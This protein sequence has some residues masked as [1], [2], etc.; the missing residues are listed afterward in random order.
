MK[1]SILNE[2]TKPTILFLVLSLF[3]L[4][5][6]FGQNVDA[7]WT[8]Y[9]G[10]WNSS[11]NNI[12][13]I[14]P[15]NSHNLLA[16]RYDG[17]VYSTG[18]NDDALTTNNVSFT[19]GNWRA[20]PINSITVGSCPPSPSVAYL[21]M[22]AQLVDGV[23]NGGSTTPPFPVENNEC[24]T[25]EVMASFLTQGENGLDL[26]SGIANIPSGTVLS[27]PFSN[28]GITQSNINDGEPD[29][30]ITQLLAPGAS[31]D[32][33][34]IVDANGNIVGNPIDVNQNNTTIVGNYRA[35]LYFRNGNILDG[36]SSTFG[37]TANQQRPIRLLAFELSDFGIN[38][39]NYTQATKLE[40][41][42]S[43][44]SDPAFFAFNE[45]SIS[46]PTSLAVTNEPNIYTDA[47]AL[48][49][50]FTVVIQ[51]DQASTV[52]EAG[53]EITA[54]IES[55][56]GTLSGD[57]TATTDA[58]GVATFSNLVINGSGDQ[59]L[60]FTSSSLNPA[61]SNVLVD[62]IAGDLTIGTSASGDS[63]SITN[64]RLISE[65]TSTIA[66]N[67]IINHL[68]N[69]GD[70]II[71]A[72][73]GE[74]IIS[75]D[76]TPN[77]SSSRV[78]SFKAEG[79]IVV[80]DDIEISASGSAMDLVFWSDTDAN[81]EGGILFRDGSNIESNNGH[82]WI[83]GGNGN[84]T[85]N[86][87]T[88]GDSYAVGLSNTATGIIETYAGI[89]AVGNALLAGSGD[90][91]LSGK[92]TQTTYRFGI[93]VRFNTSGTKLNLTGNNITISG[94]GSENNGTSGDT[95]RGNWG[96]GIEKT[97]IL[98]SG[99]IL[100]EGTGGGQNLTS[101][102]TNGGGN[103]GVR[104]DN[105]S[106]IIST[107]SGD[108]SIIGS[109]GT[110]SG[111]SNQDND[112]LRLDGGTIRV[113]TGSLSLHGTA[114]TNGSSQGI[115]YTNG[116]M[117]SRMPSST[118]SNGDLK[119]TSNTLN[120]STGVRLRSEGEL[121]ITP[122]SETTNIGIAGATGA[123]SL[124]SSYFST[125]FEDGFSNIIIG[126]DNQ[127]GDITCNTI[128]FEDNTTLQTDGNL[129]F[130]GN[131]ST[132]ANT[133]LTLI[134]N[135]LTFNTA[136]T[137][138]VQGSFAYIPFGTSFTSHV[139]FPMANLSLGTSISGLTIGNAT[140]D[141]NITINADVTGDAGIEL[142]GNDID[143]NANLETTNSANI[144]FKGNTTI[145]AGKH[146]ASNGNFTHDGDLLFK[147]D[148]TNGDAYLGSIEGNYTKTSGT[149]IT[150]KFYP[151][152]RAFRMVASP[153]DGVSI[154]DNWQN[155]GA[156]ETGIGTHI[157]GSETGDNG[158]DETETGNPSLFYF[159]NGWQAIPN[160][161]AINLTAG[162]PYR[163]MV[164]GDRDPN[165]LIDN[166]ADPNPTTLVATG[167][168]IVGTINI[169]FPSATAGSNTFAFIANPYQS[170]I[171]VSEVLT[172]NNS[173][174]DDTKLWVWDPMIN[175]RGAFV[176]I[177]ELSSGNGDTTP[178]SDAT[179]F[180]EP[181][182]A[183]FIQLIGTDSTISFTE[184]VK[185]ITT[186]LNK[187]APLSNNQMSLLF[188]LQNEENK[189][190]DAIR[191][192]FAADGITEVDAADIA[193]MGNIDE[194]LASVNQNSLFS[195]QRR[196]F[197]ENDEVIPLFTNNW[198]NQNYSFV[199]NLSNLGDVQVYMVDAYLGTETLLADGEAYHFSVDANVAESVDSQRFSLKFDAE[200]MSMEDV[201]KKWFSLYPN[202]AVD[203]VQLQ[204]NLALTGK[205]NVAVYNMLGQQ[206]QVKA[207][208]ISHSNLRLSLGHL[209]SGVYI[210][211]LTDREG[212]SY[213]QE[214]IKK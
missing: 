5:N 205:A 140:N 175:T 143:I 36:G 139:T 93:G 213:T 103:H 26:G 58:N 73:G 129:T 172:A 38:S 152:K 174:A 121:V 161:N 23:D 204:S 181:G 14:E 53:T 122:T 137:F 104:M 192:R 25:E 64:G 180:I 114:G 202:P 176:T 12:N 195:I 131:V 19:S 110:P 158:F 113:N 3:G 193:K 178:S 108:I 200:T 188:E 141:K 144:E 22:L 185:D 49:P 157:T 77:L 115:D 201:D 59:Q 48:N 15:D 208:V 27:F 72:C 71:D 186:S 130:G 189:T 148:A 166:D 145:T 24:P 78:L 32:I 191:L 28:N 83:G 70:L 8:D 62:C 165:L 154:F 153:V 55:G 162:A 60:K 164:R 159:N 203:V 194:N 123:L 199:A 183:F 81:E 88:V 50:N 116:V 87:L 40:W 173:N 132:N 9:N 84:T 42:A 30:L 17:T 198:R 56:N 39:S 167:D 120:I 65:G 211:Q 35:D 21:I 61:V 76:I 63:Y 184:S 127:T 151:A 52:I 11:E 112:G 6:A 117:E 149:V 99:N 206:M 10:Y 209:E 82:I 197:P 190:I 29:I 101:S 75:A 90:L 85:W 105:N 1:T 214:L 150:E 171:D 138:N 146:I 119:I 177:D 109:G 20:L 95:N 196:N 31:Q 147:S 126:A 124:S 179:K 7:L 18:V 163:L 4:L 212:N 33:L 156:N 13:S 54:S 41:Q 155:G 170:R 207:E 98:A 91:Y 51:D 44:Q 136:R 134:N 133:D 47:I 142:F 106:S 100:I 68:E 66:V 79:D 169:M 92:S 210:V 80:D 125:N 111:T 118:L 43:G 97:D 102:I 37:I 89:N 168:L 160:T 74:L 57:L 128:T 69:T 107:G 46:I 94:I 2:F 86:G 135:N 182:Q 96:V 34:R 16:F 45:P 187:P 67:D